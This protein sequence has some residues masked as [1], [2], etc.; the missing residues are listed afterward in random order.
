MILIVINI[1]HYVLNKFYVEKYDNLSSLCYFLTLGV[2]IIAIKL[3]NYIFRGIYSEKEYEFTIGLW[4]NCTTIM[5]L[6]QQCFSVKCPQ[7]DGDTTDF[8]NK[9]LAARAFVILACI[10]SGISALF[11]FSIGATSDNKKQ[12]ALMAAKGLAFACLIMGIIGV[13]VAI[14]GTT[15]TARATKLNW[16]AAAILGI[17]AIILN[18]CGAIA[19]VLIK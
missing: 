4:K 5:D 7:N 19:T 17:I 3:M 16:G 13:A 14:N 11:L 2:L 12:I 10:M 8:C 9:I 18:L 6:E 15:E 1:Q